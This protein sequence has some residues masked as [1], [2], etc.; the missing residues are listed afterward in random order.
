MKSL[1]LNKRAKFDYDIKDTFDAGLVLEG[2][3]VKSAKTG[4]VS[5]AGS[6]VKV[7]STGATLINAHIGPYKYAPHEGYEPTQS[8]KILL[9]KKELNQLL[10]KDKG[11]VIVPL[12]IFIGP[13]NLVK[14]KIGVGFG[15]KKAD[16][17]EYIKKRDTE[18]EARRNT[19]R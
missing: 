8:R 16:K 6:Y 7:S 14:L 12:E 13:R 1:A 4:N 11:A 15:R 9:N 10:G 5:L 19:D 2:R 3:E 17:R 18:R